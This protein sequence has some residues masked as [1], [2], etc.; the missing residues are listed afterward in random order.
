M[1]DKKKPGVKKSLE[2]RTRQKIDRDLS[3][4]RC[5]AKT[6]EGRRFLWRVL[7]RSGIFR[8]NG[9]EDAIGMARTE[10][11]RENGIELL[12]DIMSAKASL[13]GQMQQEHASEV[14]R[15]QIEKLTELEESD[16]LSLD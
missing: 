2:E 9:H 11:R 13:F 8:A 15:E 12:N 3:D 14:K 10:G 5:V 4:I 16:Q 6:P 7:S 1:T